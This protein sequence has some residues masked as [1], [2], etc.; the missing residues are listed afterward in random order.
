MKRQEEYQLQRQIC[1]YLRHQYPDVLFLS[2]TVASVQLT[3]PQAVRNKAIQ[4]EGFKCPDLIIL[5]PASGFHGLFLEL[6]KENPYLKSG[7]LTANKHIQEQA[8]SLERLRSLGYYADFA[9]TFDQATGIID[10]YFSRVK[11]NIKVYAGIALY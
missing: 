3:M 2:D 9:W 1:A 8:A 6:K 5:H 11:S 7:K 10:T 4:K